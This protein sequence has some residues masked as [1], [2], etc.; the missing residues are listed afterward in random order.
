ASRRFGLQRPYCWC[1]E[2]HVGFCEK[3]AK[4]MTLEISPDLGRGIK[5]LAIGVPSYNEIAT[6]REVTRLIDARAAQLPKRV[7]ITIVNS[8]NQ[9]PDGTSAAFS[10]VRTQ[11]AKVALLT[12]PG[13][14]GKG[15]NFLEIFGFAQRWK[16]D[17]LICLDADLEEIPEDWLLSYF[18]ALSSGADLVVPLYPRHW[19]DGN[20]TN[21]VVAPL[22]ATTSHAIRQPIG[23]D[24][25]FSKKAVS[26]LHYLKW[27][28]KAR[29]F[30]VDVFVVMRCI[31][32]GLN[33]IQQPLSTGK[34]HSW[35]SDTPDEVLAEMSTKFFEVVGM[36]LEEINR[37]PSSLCTPAKTVFP[38]AP[39]LSAPEKL[40]DPSHIIATS[41]TTWATRRELVGNSDLFNGPTYEDP[42]V[43]NDSEWADVLAA[44]VFLGRDKNKHTA[45]LKAFETLFYARLATALP[46]LRDRDVESMVVMLA[47]AVSALL[48][49]GDLK[50]GSARPSI[51]N[52]DRERNVDGSME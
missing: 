5:R 30:G 22:V 17:A 35:R 47:R 43:L 38:I 6:I 34:I 14:S 50:A 7:E 13:V 19:Y 29:G 21:Q 26:F 48:A 12:A 11:A 40:Y 28:L 10:A 8:D 45:L 23:G 37:L 51:H 24:F 52:R 15:N 4:S 25:G 42:P 18:E 20:L 39:P 46:G 31:D 9:S 3:A 33:I 32:A 1:S 16:A 44:L 49:F 2:P 27:P 41:R 36:L